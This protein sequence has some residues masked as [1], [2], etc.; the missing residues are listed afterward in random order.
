[1]T[2]TTDPSS[3]KKHTGFKRILLAFMNTKKSLLWM[4]RNESAFQQE[5]LLLLIAIPVVIVLD[6]NNYNRGFMVG[7]IIII[8]IVETLNTGL[9]A[10]VDR[11]GSEYHELSGLAK[12][13]GSA[14]VFLSFI[15]AVLVWV[16]VLF[17]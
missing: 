6:I 13:C 7:S 16:V 15:L 1:M 10:V 8:L 4:L 2:N 12:D 14:A 17:G 11:I 5:I 3:L 9:E